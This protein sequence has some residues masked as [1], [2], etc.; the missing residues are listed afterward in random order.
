MTDPAEARAR[1][2][3][4]A[5]GV[6]VL[7]RP[8]P[9]E[10]HVRFAGTF[11]GEAVEWT[12]RVVTLRRLAAETGG[13]P[14]R[15]LIEVAAVEAGVGELLVAVPVPRIDPPALVMAVTMV[16]QWKRLGPGRH[17]FGPEV[18]FGAE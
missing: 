14:V 16:R 4:E 1:T 9:E 12:A 8:D 18:D 6:R 2:L 10:A 15:A 7:S 11:A 5:A 17:P 13:G 3:L